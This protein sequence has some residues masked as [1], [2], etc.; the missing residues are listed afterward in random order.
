ML[1]DLLCSLIRCREIDKIRSVQG[2]VRQ[3][4]CMNSENGKHWR[5]SKYT[6][7]TKMLSGSLCNWLLDTRPRTLTSRGHASASLGQLEEANALWFFFFLSLCLWSSSKPHGSSL[8]HCSMALSLST[9]LLGHVMFI[10]ILRHLQGVGYS[11]DTPD[12]DFSGT[13]LEAWL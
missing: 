4:V 7:R 8:W 10:A 12:L 1:T 13:P 6:E 9:N 3:L 5:I 11:F 2:Y